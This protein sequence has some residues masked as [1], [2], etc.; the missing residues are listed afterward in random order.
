MALAG[1]V[2]L[3]RERR[4]TFDMALGAGRLLLLGGLV[5]RAALEVQRGLGVLR[6]ESWVADFAV[7]LFALGVGCVV[8]CDFAIFRGELE[9]RRRRRR[10]LLLGER[11]GESDQ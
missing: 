10:L 9:L 8:V 3:D 7:V 11:A 4:S 1:A 5:H 2:A 6:P